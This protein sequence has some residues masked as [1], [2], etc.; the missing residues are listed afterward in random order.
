M[1]GNLPLVVNGW[2]IFGAAHH[3][4]HLDLDLHAVSLHEEF[5]S[6][7]AGS[8]CSCCRSP[9]TTTEQKQNLVGPGLLPIRHPLRAAH[10]GSARLL[11][12]PTCRSKP[13][14][15]SPSSQT[16]S[17]GTGTWLLLPPSP[18]TDNSQ[19]G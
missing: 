3:I 1:S 9:A 2:A 6:P 4:V 5:V 19:S 10:L 17:A 18:M 12:A 16:S 14:N 8:F 7:A 13:A 15:S 11:T